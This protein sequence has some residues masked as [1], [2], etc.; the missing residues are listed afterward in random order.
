MLNLSINISLLKKIRFWRL[1]RRRP[2]AR[3]NSRCASG[4][5]SLSTGRCV[6]KGRYCDA[7]ANVGIR[8]C[9]PLS[10]I[11]DDVL[12]TQLQ[13]SLRHLALSVFLP[14]SAFSATSL[15][16]SSTSLSLS[17]D[18][19]PRSKDRALW[20]LTPGQ[21]PHPIYT[22]LFHPRFAPLFPLDLLFASPSPPPLIGSRDIQLSYISND[23]QRALHPEF[24]SAQPAPTFS[25]PPLSPSPI[26]LIGVF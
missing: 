20:K 5:V 3:R 19:Q 10:L 6:I 8:G 21:P 14:Y 13:L 17:L 18:L 7:S 11:N 24:N 22:T 15:P 16:H 23:L 2:N 4:E 9:Y 25:L 26:L 12:A 1:N